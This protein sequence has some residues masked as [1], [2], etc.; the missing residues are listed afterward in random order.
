MVEGELARRMPTVVVQ[1]SVRRQMPQPS[2]HCDMTVISAPTCCAISSQVIHPFSILT[3]SMVLRM[4][5]SAKTTEPK[6]DTL[7]RGQ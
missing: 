2:I 1:N 3:F 6:P 5:N 7:L 4:S